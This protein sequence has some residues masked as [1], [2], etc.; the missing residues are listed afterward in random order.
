MTSAL[1]IF[2]LS[3]A[4]VSAL[5]FGDAVI[6]HHVQR[7]DVSLV[8]ETEGKGDPV[9]FL[10]GGPG[11]TPYSVKPAQDFVSLKHMAVL[12]HQRGTG[13]T[14]LPKA[15][16]AHINLAA[17]ID[18]VDAVRK[19]LHAEKITLVGHSWGGML[20]M[21][22][23]G[24]HP[25]KV[26]HLIL[27]DSGGADLSFAAIF[28]DNIN[29]RLT[30][31]D[32]ALQKQSN[33][34][35]SKKNPLSALHYLQSILPAYFYR[36]ENAMAFEKTMKVD[37]YNPALRPLLMGYDVTKSIVNYHGPVDI[38]QGRQDP[39]DANTVQLNLKYLPQGHVHWIERAGHIPWL[40]EPADF[41]QTI[42][43]VLGDKF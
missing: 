32:L 3:L 35:A 26:S 42:S 38:I 27:M 20:A 1:R 25:D 10:A 4:F 33:E 6:E 43:L 13:K 12:I 39:I 15:D 37:D 2:A 11:V 21:A 29:M 14:A 9:V 30:D 22:Y 24:A 19:D 18:D 8:Y 7:G 28:S 17:F 40:E 16:S 41:Q 31:E 5:S 36:R 34:E 23:T